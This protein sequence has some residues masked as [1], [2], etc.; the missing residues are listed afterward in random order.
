MSEVFTEYGSFSFAAQSYEGRCLDSIVKD[1]INLPCT[2]PTVVSA[3]PDQ[4][5]MPPV[6]QSNVATQSAG[7]GV[8]IGMAAALLQQQMQ[9]QCGTMP[10]M[11]SAAEKVQLNQRMLLI[12]TGR[13]REQVSAINIGETLLSG[14]RSLFSL[15]PLKLNCH[16]K[17]KES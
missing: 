4:P 16:L 5:I 1:S 17:V 2:A 11:M 13:T 3:N 8:M 7:T 15:S 6:M 10:G 14:D 9:K 12:A